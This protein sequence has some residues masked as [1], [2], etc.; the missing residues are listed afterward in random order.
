MLSGSEGVRPRYPAAMIPPPRHAARNPQYGPE[1]VRCL[2]RSDSRQPF[3]VASLI[4]T[5]VSGDVL[6]DTRV[7]PLVIVTV[8]NVATPTTVAANVATT[9]AATNVGTTATAA[10]TAIATTAHTAIA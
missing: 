6:P 4:R 2:L 7:G 9:A 3:P 8:A 1:F 5:S 10:T